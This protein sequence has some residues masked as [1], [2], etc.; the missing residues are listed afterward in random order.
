VFRQAAK[1]FCWT[2]D[3]SLDGIDLKEGGS[4]PSLLFPIRTAFA[5]DFSGSSYSARALMATCNMAS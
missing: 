3:R 4:A 2:P 5:P 1:L